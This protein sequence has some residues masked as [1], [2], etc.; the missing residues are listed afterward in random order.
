MTTRGGRGMWIPA[1]LLLVL[2]WGS[3]YAITD[4]A[5]TGFSPAGVALWRSVIGAGFL[6]VI[7]LVTG[8]GLPRLGRSG[9][10]R[11]LVLG[12]LTTVAHVS[13]ATA[14]ARMPSGIVSILCS[15][16]PLLAVGIYWLRRA[17]IPPM[18]WVS[19]SLGVLG[20]G[21]LISPEVR[22]DRVGVM[23]GIAAAALFAVAGVLAAIFFPDSAFTGTQ[24]TAA[25]LA[26]GAVLL[27]PVA[28]ANGSVASRPEPGPLIALILLGLLA[29]GVGNVLFWRVLRTA[30]PVFAAT[31]YQSVPVVAVAVGVLALNESPRVGEIV[32]GVL[33]L[34][35]LG[36]LL[37]IVRSAGAD[38]DSRIEEGL[39]GMHC[40][41]CGALREVETVRREHHRRVHAGPD[42]LR[43]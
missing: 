30:G 28:A 23:L 19:V 1:Y 10:V 14:Q 36:L 35:G 8:T 17:P 25:Q 5:L 15:T 9:G 26:V 27:A 22:L 13:V 41:S 18:K 20:V 2:L 24:L 43:S 42:L 34:A 3:S 6:T 16:T 11:I 7:L 39:I 37:P 38:P 4:I 31:T 40:E 33:V 12:T 29:A 21:V 32:G